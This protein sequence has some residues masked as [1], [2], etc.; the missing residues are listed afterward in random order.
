MSGSSRRA[1]ALTWGFGAA[2]ALALIVALALPAGDEPPTPA[3]DAPAAAGAPAPDEPPAATAD[4]GEGPEPRAEANERRWVQL[5][6]VRLPTGEDRVSLAVGDVVA[7][8]G[9]RHL[10]GAD[11]FGARAD[12]TLEMALGS[13]EHALERAI[14][15]ALVMEAAAKRG[16]ALDE[17]ESR[18]LD[19]FEASLAR[20][21]E[22]IGP[23]L[24]SEEVALR[25]EEVHANLLERKLLALE[26]MTPHVRAEDVAE[27]LA[28]NPLPEDTEDP[29]AAEARIRLELQYER[30]VAYAEARARMLDQLREEL[31]VD[32]RTVAGN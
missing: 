4:P 16:L 24:T 2:G 11:L 32:A 13:Y 18:R 15:R 25:R 19:A 30:R 8:V 9:D 7:R 20:G 3:A 12:G 5:P 23:E 1:R 29:R 28:A 21:E 31:G 17:G 14:D 6:A 22:V 26:G 27:W 10:T